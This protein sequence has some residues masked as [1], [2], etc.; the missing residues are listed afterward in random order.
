MLDVLKSRTVLRILVTSRKKLAERTIKVY[1]FRYGYCFKCPV[2]GRL[3]VTKKQFLDHLS[4]QHSTYFRKL[5]N[6]SRP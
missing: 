6:K 5:L 2:C 3:F 1:E 4:S